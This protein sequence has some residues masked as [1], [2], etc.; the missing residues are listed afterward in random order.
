MAGKPLA[1]YA[2]SL[3]L[4]VVGRTVSRTYYEVVEVTGG[5]SHQERLRLATGLVSAPEVVKLRDTIRT[6]CLNAD[7]S[8][9]DRLATA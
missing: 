9:V 8:V 3:V 7:P 1:V 5:S 4:A 6:G 2:T